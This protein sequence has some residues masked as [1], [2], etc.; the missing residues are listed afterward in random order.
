MY[1]NVV[2]PQPGLPGW[3]ANASAHLLNLEYNQ[4]K[5]LHHRRM[6]EDAHQNI[7]P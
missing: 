2:S 3:K 5:Y 7:T 6:K 4:Q 1:W